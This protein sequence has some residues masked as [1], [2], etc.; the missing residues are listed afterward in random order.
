MGRRSSEARGLALAVLL[1]YF[2]QASLNT[3]IA[4]LSREVGMEEWHVGLTMSVSALMLAMTSSFWGRRTHLQGRQKVLV[5]AFV[6]AAT[7]TTAFTA[8][9]YFGLTGALASSAVL[10]ALLLLRGIA[11]GASVAAVQVAAQTSVAQHTGDEASRVEGMASIG[12][13]QGLAMVTGSLVGGGLAA[14]DLA[15]PIAFASSLLIVGVVMVAVPRRPTRATD[16]ADVVAQVRVRD[17]RVWPFLVVGFGV[18]TAL[19]FTQVLLGFLIQDRLSLD[20]DA[21]GAVTGMAA[22]VAGLALIVSQAVIVP[23]TG[24]APAALLRSGGGL[25][26]FGFVLLI[27]DA[28]PIALFIAVA[29][30]GT[31]VGICLPGY[32]AGP[33]LLVGQHEQ[34]AVAGLLTANSGVTFVVSPVVGTTLYSASPPLPFCIAAL[35]MGA[36]TVFTVRHPLFRRTDN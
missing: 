20:A 16:G 8:V 9:A 17:P 36:V 13:I 30:I 27:P 6:L 3:V 2:V 32:Q 35:I 18:F 25:T 21:T 11:F 23:R 29:V 28:G 10:A 14:V 34:G 22:M 24:W 31:G 15:A 5:D 12:S 19:G 7:S 1:I 26:L 4:P 33:S